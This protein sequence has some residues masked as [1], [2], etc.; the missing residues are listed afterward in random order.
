MKT[1]G[2]R[3]TMEEFNMRK[4]AAVLEAET[5]SYREV[6]EDLEHSANGFRAQVAKCRET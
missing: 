4:E 6:A 5:A 3:L 1:K 2:A